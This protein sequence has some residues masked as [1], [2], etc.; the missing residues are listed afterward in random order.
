MTLWELLKKY[1]MPFDRNFV[2]FLAKRSLENY[3]FFF[4]FI[5][6]IAS[7]S[8]WKPIESFLNVENEGQIYFIGTAT[9]FVF[10][11]G[12]FLVAKYKTWKWFPAFVFSVCVSRVFTELNPEFAQTYDW[13]EYAVFCLTVLTFTF[14][15]LKHKWNKFYKDANNKKL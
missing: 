8:F 1:A 5:I 11:T 3:L 9:A 7:N 15:F 12:A 14:Y 10:Y 13:T 2:V 6:A 4:G